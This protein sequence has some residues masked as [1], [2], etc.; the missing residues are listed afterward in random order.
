M[1]WFKPKRDTRHAMSTSPGEWRHTGITSTFTSQKVRSRADKRSPS[2]IVEKK[3]GQQRGGSRKSS[4]IH[5]HLYT[6]SISGLFL[7]IVILVIVIKSST[8]FLL[9]LWLSGWELLSRAVFSGNRHLDSKKMILDEP[10]EQGADHSPDMVVCSEQDMIWVDEKVDSRE[11][12]ETA[13]IAILAIEEEN[14]PEEQLDDQAGALRSM[15]AN[16]SQQSDHP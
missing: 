9:D 7:L 14:L 5:H 16:A 12:V 15:L 4:G 11:E 6:N 1:S 10:Q 2:Q 13:K 3:L 8:E